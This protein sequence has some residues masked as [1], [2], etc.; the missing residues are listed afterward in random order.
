MDEDPLALDTRRKLYEAVRR[1]PGIGGR[2]VQRAAGTGW[3]ET[4][5]HLD[6]L[7][8]AGLL[9][10]ERDAHQ[11]HYFARGVPLA[12]RNLLRL[13]RSSSARRLL[14]ALLERPDQTVPDLSERTRLSPGRLSVH[15]RRLIDTGIVATGRSGRLRTFRVSDQGRVVRVL[16]AY[17]QSFAD[18]WVEGLLD[19]WGEIFRP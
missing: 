11:D 17:R 4:V 16:V 13:S 8:E 12:D 5:Y 19:T 10:R 2:E 15:L 18:E 7:T 1:S 9:E 6:R 3:G 14:V